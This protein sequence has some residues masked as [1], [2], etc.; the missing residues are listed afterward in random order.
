MPLQSEARPSYYIPWV[1]Q[2]TD[3][4]ENTEFK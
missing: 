3:N 2:G 4:R 1:L